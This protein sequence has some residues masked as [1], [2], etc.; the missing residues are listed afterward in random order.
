MKKPKTMA[1]ICIKLE[2]TL[3][4]TYNEDYFVFCGFY[5]RQPVEV[6]IIKGYRNQFFFFN[7]MF[8]V[9]D[10]L[11]IGNL[12][13]PILIFYK[14]TERVFQM[15]QREFENLKVGDKVIVVYKEEVINTGYVIAITDRTWFKWKNSSFLTSYF[16]HENNF[17][18]E[19]ES[20]D[21]C[22]AVLGGQD[23]Q[24]KPYDL[25]LSPNNKV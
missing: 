1:D 22:S 21:F 2:G 14:N 12:K 3:S 24:P 20:M 6:V 5:K 8:E 4:S 19:I 7:S 16:S 23:K 17:Y 13:A 11:S 9:I 15:N 18:S 25:V 10:L